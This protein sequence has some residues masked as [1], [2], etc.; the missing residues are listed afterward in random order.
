MNGARTAWVVVALLAPTYVAADSPP[1]GGTVWELSS[2]ILDDSDP[3][4]FRS[5]TY[6]GRGE[7]RF[8]DVHTEGWITLNVYL[9]DVRYGSRPEPTE[10]QVHHEY[11][12]RAAAREQ[13]DFYAPILGRMPKALLS[14]AKVVELSTASPSHG[15]MAGANRDGTF[16]IHT[17]AAERVYRDGFLEEVL[18]HEAGHVS[19]DA[20]HADAPGWVAAQRE[21]PAFISGYARDWPRREDVAESILAYFAVRYRPDRLSVD[22][23]Q[24]ILAAVPA[25]LAYFDRQSFDMA[26]YR[27]V[28]PVPA[29][30]LGGLAALWVLLVVARRRLQG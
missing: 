26:P 1:F 11:G 8:W 22:Q 21:D 5:V 23:E 20:D 18:F 30:P 19:L 7:R 13:V 28:M 10:Y 17:D 16:H 12:S 2:T 9:F 29:V 6:K 4:S 25:R 24:K 15:A 27:P 3:S 14:N